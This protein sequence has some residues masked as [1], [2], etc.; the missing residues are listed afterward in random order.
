MVELPGWGVILETGLSCRVTSPW[1][2][3]DVVHSWSLHPE[4]PSQTPCREAI[5]EGSGTESAEQKCEDSG[6]ESFITVPAHSPA[7]LQGL[8]LSATSPTILPEQREM[9]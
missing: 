1:S 7:S 9:E 6:S 3:H 4:G 8:S 5:S 2:N